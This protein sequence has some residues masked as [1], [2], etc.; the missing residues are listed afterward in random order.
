MFVGYL[1]KSL[2]STF[3]S[4]LPVAVLQLACSSPSARFY[5]SNGSETISISNHILYQHRYV[6]STAREKISKVAISITSQE[7]AFEVSQVT[8]SSSASA[9]AAGSSTNN[10]IPRL[11][12]STRVDTSQRC[13]QRERSD[14]CFGS[15]AGEQWAIQNRVAS[16]NYREQHALQQH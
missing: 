8:I 1:F 10:S 16:L 15:I 2:L 9:I 5:C 11:P 3:G 7:L 4:G 12:F 14:T 13:F 6:R